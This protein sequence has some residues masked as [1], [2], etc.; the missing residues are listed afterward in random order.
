MT[1]TIAVVNQKGGVG[2]STTVVN[3]GAALA[4]KGDKTLVVDMDPQ[5]NSTSGVGVTKQGVK[6]CIYDVLVNESPIN[7]AVIPTEIKNLS[8]VPATIRLAGA[9]VEL[10]SVF[11]R[12]FRLKEALSKI[13]NNF[14]YV[15]ID[16][17]PSLGLLTV[18][19]MVACCELIIPIQCEYYALEGLGQLT[20]TID[21]IK[22][23]LNKEINILGV[24]LTMFD[25]RT[26]L[27]LQVAKE[28][29]SYFKEVVFKTIIP[30]NVKISE[31]PSFGKPA[32][33]YD[34]KCLGAKAY[35]ALAK[36][37]EKRCAATL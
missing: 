3:L 20:T 10:V 6:K 36:E 19:S 14:S 31:A 5:G 24:I 13:K 2:K 26:N 15:L 1:R 17:P 33:T 27:S 22:R 32:T 34:P 35:L 29:R 23:H 4:Q 11:S 8:L 12:E 21:M 16:C 7:K 37:V 30:R 9:E 28:V 25:K 18:N